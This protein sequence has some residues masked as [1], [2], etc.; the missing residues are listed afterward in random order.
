M[1]VALFISNFATSIANAG[2]VPLNLGGDLMLYPDGSLTMK[3]PTTAALTESLSAR[4]KVSIP[5]LTQSIP[6]SLGNKTVN[7]KNISLNAATSSRLGRAALNLGR[8]IGPLAIGL[9]LADTFCILVDICSPTGSPTYQKTIYTDTATW[10]KPNDPNITF[11]TPIAACNAFLSQYGF[12]TQRVQA[13]TFDSNG[14]VMSYDCYIAGYDDVQANTTRA[15]LVTNTTVRAPTSEDWDSAYAFMGT[16]ELSLAHQN[17]MAHTIVEKKEPL[18]VDDAQF[19]PQVFM[20]DSKVTTVRD[21]TGIATGYDTK[22]TKATVTQAPANNLVVEE[23][24]T[25]VKKNADGTTA[26]S[27]TTV[28][29][30]IPDSTPQGSDE[31]PKYPTIEIDN[32]PDIDLPTYS[33][34]VTLSTTSWGDG[35]CPSNPSISLHGLGTLTLPLQPVCNAMFLIRPVII[36]LAFMAAAYIMMGARKN[37]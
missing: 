24:T 14:K 33:P 6:T 18:P 13:R 12:V 23:S 31:P 25:V 15:T 3:S 34:P 28:R 30:N 2:S 19:V 22:E 32:T 36:L 27:E 9:A 5:S 29:P 17:I 7:L 37:D 35:T 1:L 26:S 16:V 4:P 21:A 11:S 8:R 10:K 20:L